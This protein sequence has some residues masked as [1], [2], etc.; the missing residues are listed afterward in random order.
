MSNNSIKVIQLSTG[1]SI[2]GKIVNET[3]SQIKLK[4]VLEVREVMAQDPDNPQAEPQAT[5]T[6]LPFMMF[7]KAMDEVLINPDQVVL[8]AEPTQQILNGYQQQFGEIVTP[9]QDSKIIT[10]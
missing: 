7:S 6:F 4:N 2:L 1:Q 5:V 9:T 10:P 8:Y 3:D